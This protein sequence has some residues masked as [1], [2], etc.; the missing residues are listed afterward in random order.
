MSFLLALWI[1]VRISSAS[2]LDGLC[3]LAHSMLAQSKE[4]EFFQF[5]FRRIFPPRDFT[6]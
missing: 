1:Q 3:S 4:E 6:W 2:A 5:Y